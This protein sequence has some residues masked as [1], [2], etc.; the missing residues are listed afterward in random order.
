MYSRKPE[1][2]DIEI[3]PVCNGDGLNKWIPYDP[4]QTVPLYCSNCKGVGKISWLDYIYNRPRQGKFKWSMLE[5]KNFTSLHGKDIEE[6]LAKIIAEEIDK[7]ILNNLLK[8][9][10]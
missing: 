3:C 6:E 5:T 8:G 10:N 1:E 2:D 4:N 7:E 9:V